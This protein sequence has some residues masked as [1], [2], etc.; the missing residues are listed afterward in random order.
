MGKLATT[1][2]SDLGKQQAFE[3][4]N[5]GKLARK[6]NNEKSVV[7]SM[8]IIA[9]YEDPYE[10]SYEGSRKGFEAKQGGEVGD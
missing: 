4:A 1:I 5:S 2:L 9:G 10:K 3:D 8:N 6:A 7:Q